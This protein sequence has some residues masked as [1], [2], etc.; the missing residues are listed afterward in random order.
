MYRSSFT[1][2]NGGRAAWK[3]CLSGALAIIVER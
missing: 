1:A 2:D 3:Q